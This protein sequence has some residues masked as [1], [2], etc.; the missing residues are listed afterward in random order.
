MTIQKNSNLIPSVCKIFF[1]LLSDIDTIITT[2]DRFHRY[3][4]F[5]SGKSWQQ[6]Y[7]SPGSAELLE[8][9]KD[10]D[11]GELIEQSLKFTFPGEDELNLA[12]LDAVL[13]HPAIVKVEY[14]TGPAKLLGDQSNGAKLSQINQVSSKGAGSD[15]Q[16]AC[17]ATNRACWITP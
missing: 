16:F 12:A 13:N 14:S 17:L 11:A 15:L 2:P 7:L 6:I 4:V 1:A 10:T 8:R 3:I 5:K 9:S